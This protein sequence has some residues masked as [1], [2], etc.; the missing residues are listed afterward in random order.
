MQL[1]TRNKKYIF[2]CAQNKM[3]IKQ[4]WKKRIEKK[5]EPNKQNIF[6]KI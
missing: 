1:C 4:K 2:Q 3:K 5:N 6:S